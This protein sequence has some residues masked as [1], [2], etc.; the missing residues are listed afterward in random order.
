MQTLLPELSNFFLISMSSFCLL[1]CEIEG[2][3]HLLSFA[4]IL[5]R[6]IFL[7]NFLKQWKNRIINHLTTNTIMRT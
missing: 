3:Y 7:L 5:K 2:T 4:N 6:R 1:I